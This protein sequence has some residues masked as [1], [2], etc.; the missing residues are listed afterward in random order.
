MRGIVRSGNIVTINAAA[1]NFTL[2]I[3]STLRGVDVANVA[4]A[5][6]TVYVVRRAWFYYLGT[7]AVARLI[8]GETV[9]FA[10]RIIDFDIPRGTLVAVGQGTLIP[11]PAF[12]FTTDLIVRS[13]T[14]TGG[15]VLAQAEVLDYPRFAIT[16]DEED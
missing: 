12:S 4:T 15:N 5:G 13:N 9:A 3:A 14:V 8:L 1:T 6:S 11:I 10:Q 2:F 7:D 16:Q